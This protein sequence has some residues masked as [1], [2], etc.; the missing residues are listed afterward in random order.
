[1]GN[2]IP[3]EGNLVASKGRRVDY[4]LMQHHI[5]EER[6]PKLHHY[7]N[8]RT[9]NGIYPDLVFVDQGPAPWG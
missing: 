1:M 7:K 8:I 5:P 6:N 3:Y 2:R 9:P 4:P